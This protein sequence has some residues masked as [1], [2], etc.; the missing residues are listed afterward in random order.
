[1]KHEREAHESFSLYISLFLS[2]LFYKYLMRA[3][4][5]TARITMVMTDKRRDVQ[6]QPPFMLLFRTASLFCT[7][8]RQEPVISTWSSKSSISLRWRSS[9]SLTVSAMCFVLS[10]V[11]SSFSTPSCGELCFLLVKR[12]VNERQFDG[13]PFTLL[14]PHPFCHSS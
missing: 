7:L 6:E 1:M 8:W 2:P 11:A 9:S 3:Q 12:N 4:A 14:V 10:T 5:T 13:T